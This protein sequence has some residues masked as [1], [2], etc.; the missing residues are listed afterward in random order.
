MCAQRHQILWKKWNTIEIGALHAT[1]V[2]WLDYLYMHGVFMQIDLL[3][4]LFFDDWES[5]WRGSCIIVATNSNWTTVLRVVRVSAMLRHISVELL[6]TVEILW[7][8]HIAIFPKLW[9]NR[10]VS[11]PEK[12]PAKCEKRGSCFQKIWVCLKILKACSSVWLIGC[13]AYSPAINGAVL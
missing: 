13:T 3:L 8:W 1:L 5:F 4:V 9:D 10:Q 11:R 6:N 7:Q 12:F 2:W